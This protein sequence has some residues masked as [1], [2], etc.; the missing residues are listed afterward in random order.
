MGAVGPDVSQERR[1]S[2]VLL[3]KHC[4]GGQDQPHHTHQMS[5][6]KEKS[7]APREFV[8]QPLTG[9]CLLP[10]QMQQNSWNAS[11]NTNREREKLPLRLDI[12]K[13]LSTPQLREVHRPAV[14]ALPD[15]EDL[16]DINFETNFRV[17]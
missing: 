6:G 15:T 2:G 14:M 3:S 11:R 4:L 16:S 8:T 10:L 9:G 7:S 17:C 12:L 5:R 13:I 1:T